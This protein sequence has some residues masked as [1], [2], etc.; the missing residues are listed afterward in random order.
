MSKRPHSPSFDYVPGSSQPHGA[1]APTVT[2]NVTLN[3]YFSPAPRTEA[4]AAPPVERWLP[5]APPRGRLSQTM[6][7]GIRIKC[8]Q[9]ACSNPKHGPTQFVPEKNPRDKKEYLETIDALQVATAAK[10]AAAFEE[11]RGTIDRLKTA[12]CT[13]CR[14]VMAKCQANPTTASGACRA[15]WAR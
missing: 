9:P 10:D 3:A 4:P 11:A 7:G 14:A 1:P 6:G 8:N 15:E 2:V 12:N 5:A 13:V